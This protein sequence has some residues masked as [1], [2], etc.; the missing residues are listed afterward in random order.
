MLLKEGDKI[1]VAHRRLFEK[2]AV[3]FLV[4]RA[5][6]WESFLRA[7][8]SS[9]FALLLLEETEFGLLCDLLAHAAVFYMDETGWK[10]GT[11]G[12][13]LWAFASKLH[14]VFLF[15]CRKDDATLD[16]ML[17]PNVFDG[18]GVRQ[19]RSRKR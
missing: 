1:L 9:A 11:E 15:G 4:G 10:V 16:A 2:D 19:M 17:P 14:R 18:I 3:R 13:S 7:L 8:N 12:C 5:E 6:A